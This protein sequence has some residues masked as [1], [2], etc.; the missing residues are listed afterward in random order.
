LSGPQGNPFPLP[1]RSFFCIER[2][3]QKKSTSVLLG[4]LP[5]F[6]FRSVFPLFPGRYFYLRKY[7]S[8]FFTPGEVFLSYWFF[9]FFALGVFFFFNQPPPPCFLFFLSV[10]TIS[11]TR[12][13]RCLRL[14][15]Q[16]FLAGASRGRLAREFFSLPPMFFTFPPVIRVPFPFLHD[17]RTPPFTCGG[18]LFGFASRR[19][20]SVR[21][22]LLLAPLPVVSPPSPWL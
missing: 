13:P 22:F 21:L 3:L 4:S 16:T 17:W 10:E 1:G 7:F 6:L 2:L 5:E 11:C 14:P 15:C 8:F 19:G 20:V 18:L 12:G 9:F